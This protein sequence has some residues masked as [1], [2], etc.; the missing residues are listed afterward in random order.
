MNKYT[1][2]DAWFY[3][4]ENYATR[5]ER[6]Y[7]DYDLYHNI[8]KFKNLRKW[9]EAAFYSARLQERYTLEVKLDENGDQIIEFPKELLKSNGW[10]IGTVV[11]WHDNG[12]GS[13]T[14]KGKA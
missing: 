11:S 12:D 1:D 7:D 5:A 4:I 9:L 8:G 10:D 2:F 13:W 6:C 3:E 14:I